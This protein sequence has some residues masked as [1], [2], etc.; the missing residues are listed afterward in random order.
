M[1]FNEWRNRYIDNH[2]KHKDICND[3]FEK[4][5]YKIET[6]DLEIIDKQSLYQEFVL[7]LYT[8][9]SKDKYNFN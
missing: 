7:Y 8:H 6:L 4:L 1:F 2:I 3:L 5:L 9:S